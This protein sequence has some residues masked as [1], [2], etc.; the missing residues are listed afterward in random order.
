MKTL[1]LAFRMEWSNRSQFFIHVSVLILVL[2]FTL[3]YFGAY[4]GTIYSSI[5]S[6]IYELSA[7]L[8]SSVSNDKLMQI[9][10]LPGFQSV[11]LTAAETAEID[12]HTYQVASI[13]G[14]LSYSMQ[15]D[16]SDFSESDI[17]FEKSVMLVPYAYTLQ[18]GK[19]I[20]DTLNLNGT[21]YQI[22]GIVGEALN[23]Y[24]FVPY[25]TLFKSF[26]PLGIQIAL[27]SNKISQEQYADAA[28]KAGKI[29]GVS[30]EKR[31]FDQEFSALLQ[32]RKMESIFYFSLGTI[33]LVFVYSYILFQRLKRLAIYSLHGSTFKRLTAILLIG[34]VVIFSV[35]FVIAYI[36]GRAV[37]SF[38]FSHFFDY[39]TF[40]LKW[41]DLVF[42]FAI[43]L[44]IYLVVLFLYLRRFRRTSAIGAYRRKE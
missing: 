18:S 4:Y 23:G 8:T 43:T 22:I 1:F 16:G 19:N 32:T 7:S 34:S 21:D 10:S 42:F 20:G 14:Q 27:D 26:T 12:G 33:S 3:Q 37:N 29:L 38:V 2:Y 11:F 30:I 39:D 6:Q 36:L 44:S 15:L 25:T 9:E 5:G 35:G 24:F 28:V 41:G 13:V 40:A 31:D 17:A